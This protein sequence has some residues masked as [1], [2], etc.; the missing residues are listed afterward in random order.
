[1]N[2]NGTLPPKVRL[3]AAGC[4]LSGLLYL[5]TLIAMYLI[6]FIKPEIAQPLDPDGQWVIPTIG[7]LFWVSFLV[8]LIAWSITQSVHPFVDQAGHTAW[9]LSANLVVI[10]VVFFSLEILILS[11]T[12]GLNGSVQNNY[13][14]F[15]FMF[16]LWLVVQPAL[17]LFHV[18]FTMV[19]SVR[20][21]YG[22]LSVFP[23]L[24]LIKR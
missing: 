6:L 5:M 4:Y 7:L 22:Q 11:I 17:V 12:C 16:L 24:P 2:D 21:A 15:N 14:I 10:S 13:N 18:L 20:A 3:L 8:P 9:N 19:G 1:M 23:L